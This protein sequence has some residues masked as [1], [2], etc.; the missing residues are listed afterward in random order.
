MNAQ[1]LLRSK[2][3]GTLALGLV[4]L[5]VPS[6]VLG[7][8]GVDGTDSFE[9]FLR[10][11]GLLGLGFGIGIL[12]EK[13]VLLPARRVCII[14]VVLDALAA[15]L[16]SLAILGH[17]INAFGWILVAMYVSSILTYAVCASK[18]Q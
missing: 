9:L 12:F 11:Y 13:E 1:S 15:V 10:L 2:G 18:V 7:V 5:F 8:L 16:L 17:Y 6:F 14:Y 3:M 4:F